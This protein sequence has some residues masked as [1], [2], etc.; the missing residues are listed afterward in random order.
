MII[1]YR[2]SWNV[3]CENVGESAPLAVEK[4]YLDLRNSP[5]T[6]VF[7]NPTS[8]KVYL[9]LEKET[10]LIQLLDARGKVLQSV[11]PSEN[12]VNFD[13]SKLVNGTYWI[14]NIMNKSSETY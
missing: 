14:R 4:A 11:K 5:E 6:T 1:S 7:P 9:I 13:L 12:P 8:G 3:L 2:W 10:D